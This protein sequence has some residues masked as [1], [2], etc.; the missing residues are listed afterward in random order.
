MIVKVIAPFHLPGQDADGCLD[1]PEGARV[2][3]LLRL[4]RAPL[5]AHL[6]PVSVNGEQSPRSRELKDGDVV[7]FIAPI[8]GG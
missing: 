3:S 7:I 2:Q 6:L 4:G 1:L 5:Y 8:S